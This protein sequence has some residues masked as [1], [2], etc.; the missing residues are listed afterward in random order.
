MRR[1]IRLIFVEKNRKKRERQLPGRCPVARSRN[2]ATSSL[3]REGSSSFNS[4]E[5][6]FHKVD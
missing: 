1:R 2:N 5:L 6:M 4:A 3:S